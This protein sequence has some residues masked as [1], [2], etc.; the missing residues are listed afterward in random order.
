MTSI[1]IN[2]EPI[3]KPHQSYI[4]TIE[5][6]HIVT[7]M[8]WYHQHCLKQLTAQNVQQFHVNII[9]QMD[10]PSQSYQFMITD[11]TIGCRYS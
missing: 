5:N 8:H 6:I 2:S 10:L 9:S 7:D 11:A 3:A 1:S 4:K